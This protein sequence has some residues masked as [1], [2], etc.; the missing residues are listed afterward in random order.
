MVSPPILQ[1]CVPMV[2]IPTLHDCTGHQAMPHTPRTMSRSPSGTPARPTASGDGHG[3]AH[4]EA[5][6]DNAVHQ[7]AVDWHTRQELGL[8]PQEAAEL[9]QWLAANPLHRAAMQRLETSMKLLRDLPEAD[10]LRLR[11]TRPG[12]VP[13]RHC[14]PAR[15]RTPS[16]RRWPASL[17]LFSRQQAVAALLASVL[18]VGWLGWQHWPESPSFSERYATSVGERR[19]IDLPDG[20]HLLLDTDTRLSVRFF[21]GRREVQMAHGQALFDIASN[22]DKPFEVLAGDARATVV[23]TRFSVRYLT[24]G[25]D[26]QSVDV[27]VEE[28]RVR[29]RNKADTGMAPSADAIELSAGQ[30]VRVSP[31]GAIGTLLAVPENQIASWRSGLLHFEDMPLEQALAELGRYGPT[32]LVIRDP[33]VAA[34]R[35]GGSYPTQHPEQ[36]AQV[37]TRILPVHLVRQSDGRHEVRLS[38]SR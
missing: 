32:G 18:L 9:A 2:R 13:V 22:A 11:A 30:A 33:A 3:A 6:T 21:A 23:G 17:L 12:T 8:N 1:A 29:V 20:S 28:G 27:A 38:P 16:P 34:L 4:D 31:S 7:A 35:I 5:L 24:G 19:G 14:P 36:F 26:A 25:T 10:R 37:L 15:T